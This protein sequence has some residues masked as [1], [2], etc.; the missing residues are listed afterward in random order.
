MCSTSPS[1]NST[2]NL[3]YSTCDTEE[4]ETVKLIE[5][6]I[7]ISHPLDSMTKEVGYSEYTCSL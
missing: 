7:N 4:S 3:P 1:L 2:D 6:Q 5:E